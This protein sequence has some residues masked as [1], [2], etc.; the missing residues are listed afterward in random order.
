MT[1]HS[2]KLT[3]LCKKPNDATHIELDGTFW[4]NQEGNWYHWNKNFKQWCGY[5]GNANKD[6]LNKLM[7][8]A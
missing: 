1:E 2:V 3:P 4:K 5:A 7:T 8:V 6:F